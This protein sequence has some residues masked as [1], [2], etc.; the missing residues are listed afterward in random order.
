M[1]KN[2]MVSSNLISSYGW[3]L[4]KSKEDGQNMFVGQIHSS[5]LKLIWEKSRTNH[6][7]IFSTSSSSFHEF[8]TKK[9]NELLPIGLLAQLEE[10]CDGI[11]VVKGSTPLQAWFSTQTFK[12]GTFINIEENTKKVGMDKI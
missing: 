6:K 1:S 2:K 10:R 9:L 5:E 11:A 7:L 12:E 8:L 3:V 4:L